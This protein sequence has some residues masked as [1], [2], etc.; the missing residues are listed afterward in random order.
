MVKCLEMGL[1]TREELNMGVLQHLYTWFSGKLNVKEN[2][3]Q[4]H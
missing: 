4:S 2:E 3:V 1:I